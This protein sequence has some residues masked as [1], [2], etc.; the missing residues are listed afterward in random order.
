MLRQVILKEVNTLI[1]LLILLTIK[2]SCI[3][4]IIMALE[5]QP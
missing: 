4:L 3:N 1:N 5:A 2:F